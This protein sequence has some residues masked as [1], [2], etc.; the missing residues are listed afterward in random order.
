MFSDLNSLV[1]L[2]LSRNQICSIEDDTFVGL[3][4]LTG[5]WIDENALDEVKKY[6]FKGLNSL[7]ELSLDNNSIH[8]IEDDTFFSVPG[9]KKLWLECN[10]KLCWLKQGEHEGWIKW[11]SEHHGSGR[12]NCSN[13]MEWKDLTFEC[14][15]ISK[16]RCC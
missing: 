4:K 5:L 12:P 10:A 6:D 11:I 3:G 2:S 13:G 14:S 8:S 16:Y 9:L 15:R 1:N 7:L